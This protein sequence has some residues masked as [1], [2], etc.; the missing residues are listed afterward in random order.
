MPLY[1][2]KVSNLKKYSTYCE[3]LLGKKR[4]QK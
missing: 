3:E 4:K 2:A 1:L